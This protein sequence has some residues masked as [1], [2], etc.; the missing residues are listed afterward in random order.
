VFRFLAVGAVLTI[1]GAVMTV[2]VAEAAPP[3][4]V[5]LTPSAAS[6]QSDQLTPLAGSP[7]T[8]VF[9]E[10][11]IFAGDTDPANAVDAP[12]I[13]GE[14][15]L[16][17]RAK[18]GR[19]TKLGVT[20]LRAALYSVVGTVITAGK[21]NDTQITSFTTNRVYDRRQTATGHPAEIRSVPFGW[22][23]RDRLRDAV[24]CGEAADPGRPREHARH[25][26]RKP[27]RPRATVRRG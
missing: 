26:V 24:R 18:N 22:A 11:V 8:L 9:S 3:H 5:I 20:A 23:T 14:D 27:R 21:Y 2:P 1:A 13:N 25:A 12:Y 6:T 7:S 10:R 15:V 16:Y 4:D 17:A 19:L